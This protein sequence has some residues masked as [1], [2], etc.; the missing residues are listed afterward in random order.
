MMGFPE[1]R[2]QVRGQRIDEFT[3]LI[4]IIAGF[5]IIT[6][7]L[8]TPETSLAQAPRQPAVHQFTLAL[9]QRDTGNL[10]DNSPNTLK[11]LIGEFKFT[12]R[13]DGLPAAT[14]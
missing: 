9:R 11:I 5:Q 2:G 14:V 13:H 6:I 8:E 1:E 4:F 7:V 12:A 3:K 10:V